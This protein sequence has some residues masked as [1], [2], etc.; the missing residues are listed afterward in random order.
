MFLTDSTIIP[1]KIDI[2]LMFSILCTVLST[3]PLIFSSFLSLRPVSVPAVLL[4]QGG[5][6]SLAVE[7]R[8]GTWP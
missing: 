6:V 1:E 5:S 2:R 8:G 7:L 4:L 3:C